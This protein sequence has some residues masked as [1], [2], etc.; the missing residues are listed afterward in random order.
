MPP[1]KFYAEAKM[2][3]KE[4]A[5]VDFNFLQY[6]R[7]G[8]SLQD[9]RTRISPF[10]HGHAENRITKLR[11]GLMDAPKARQSIDGLLTATI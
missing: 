11:K 3:F 2:M 1:S 6:Q 10:Y 5:K 7:R 8:R 4:I 9:K